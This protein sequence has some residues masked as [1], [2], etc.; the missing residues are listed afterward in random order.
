V[1]G[2][3]LGNGIISLHTGRSHTELGRG[4]LQLCRESESRVGTTHCPSSQKERVSCYQLEVASKTQKPQNV[5]LGNGVHNLFTYTPSYALWQGQFSSPNWVKPTYPK[6][7][8]SVGV[9]RAQED[10]DKAVARGAGSFWSI[11]TCNGHFA[12]QMQSMQ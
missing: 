11:W 10:N 3:S 1:S 9:G 5:N 2:R 12:D 6:G 7:S 8:W 4:F